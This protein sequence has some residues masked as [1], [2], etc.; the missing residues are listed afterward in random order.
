MHL[1]RRPEVTALYQVGRDNLE[2]LYG[3]IEDGA[4]WV[5]IPKDAR[6][7]LKGYLACGLVC[8]DFARL[9]GEECGE[10]R[11]GGVLLQGAGLLP[12]VPGTA[13]ERDHREPNRA[14]AV[15]AERASAVGTDL[16]LCLVASAVGGRRAARTARRWAA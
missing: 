13:D 5:R 6:K 12:V 3:A 9:R 15:A 4:L 1:R 7:E 14:R 16:P 2:T 10:K 11:P 8:W